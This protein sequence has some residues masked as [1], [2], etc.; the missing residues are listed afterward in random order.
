MKYKTGKHDQEKTL[1][2]VKIPIEFYETKYE[3]LNEKIVL[4]K[5]KEIFRDR[6]HQ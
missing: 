5:F 3:G 1:I 4:S 2:S 6:V